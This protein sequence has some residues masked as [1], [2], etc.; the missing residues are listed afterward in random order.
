MTMQSESKENKILEQIVAASEEF[1]QSAG[2]K[3][4]YQKITDTIAGISGAKYAVFSLY[5]EGGNKFITTAITAPEGMIKKVSSLLGFKLLGKKW[6]YD[7]VRAW[8]T[9]S[10]TITHLSSLLELTGD[11]IPKPVVYLLEKT[12][13]IGEVVFVK[14]LKEN[15]M[16]G[17]FTLV[18]PNN[19]T[20]R[21]DNYV[22]LYSRQLGLLIT[23][24]RAENA[25]LESEEKFRDLAQMLPETI[26]EMNGQGILTFVNQHGFEVFGYT[27]QDFDRGV[28]GLDMLIPKD[29]AKA[30]KVIQNLFNGG[31]SGP[32]E[33]TAQR[34][35]GSTLPILLR[36]SAIFHDGK[37]VGLRGMVFD[38]TERK[39]VEEAL[40]E[41]KK[42]IERYLNI[43]AEIIISLD[44]LGNITMINESG[45]QLLG[46]N[47]DELIG[48]NWLSTCI[49]DE[50]ISD[51]KNVF[52]KIISGDVGNVTNFE[53]V[54]K[55]KSGEIRTIFW[56]NTILRDSNGNVTGTISS[57]EDITERKKAED[58][59]HMERERL[60]NILEGTNAGTWEWNIQTKK[61]V[62]NERW[63]EIIGYTLAEISPVSEGT[64][65]RFT[66]PDDI[67][68]SNEQLRRVFSREINY[69]DVECRMRHKNG[70]W[71]W[72]QD[73]GKVMSWTF[74][75]KP[76]W[77]SGTH[78]DIT[79][80]KLSEEALQA[81]EEK[82]SK[83]FKT[84]HHAI[85]ITR[86]KDGRFIEVNEAFTIITGFSR[87]EACADSSINLKIWVDIGNRDQVVSMLKE[88]MDVKNK[89][90]KFRKK[91]GAV[92]IGLFSAQIVHINNEPFMFSSISDITDRKKA[93]A[94]ILHLS[95][96]D[97]LTGL[98]NR[99]FFEEEL[100]RLDTER[101]L[102]ISFIMGDLNGLKIINDVFGHDEGDRLL[103][104]TG[105]ILK[106]VCRSDDILARWGGDEFVILLPKTFIADAEDIAE[107]I[108]K[109]CKK[110]KNQKIALSLSLGSAV[111]ES[112]I[113][114]IRATLV[115]A[116][117]NMYKNKLIEKQSLTSS[118]IFALEQALYEKS[119]ETKEHTDRIHELA[120][121]LGK[122]IKL[123]SSQLDELSLLAS[124][125]DI[126]KVAIPETILLKK[127]K[128]T[129]KEWSTIKR[130]PEI[131]FNIAQSSPQIAHIA[132]PILYCHENFDGS[133]YPMGIK[134]HEI[135]VISRIILIVDSYDV[136]TS[137]RSYKPAISKKDAITEIKRNAG[138]QFDPALVEKF[139]ELL[140][141]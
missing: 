91:N 127:G 75:G 55:T 120:G 119:N 69:Y 125:H 68:K 26:F 12:F 132:K 113:Q 32:N 122:S 108:K 16:I 88:G 77:M 114:D 47:R 86:L 24:K 94:E 49:P 141:D 1:L 48:R 95:F 126:G 57:G 52:E 116:E 39:R 60:A 29:R 96:H 10:S 20:L 22:E 97:H 35:D 45:H 43:V 73:R 44:N 41:S 62:Y 109:E 89:E 102:P 106:T 110:S 23:R 59:L 83:A 123:S 66:H 53:N 37:A 36:S 61:T 15:T 79:E 34:I 28:N 65:E 131:G 19:V 80:R 70:S 128:L 82:F 5:D 124:L 18:M 101:Q 140:A 74:D 4:N 90:F 54:V 99:R 67:E 87:E 6:D 64:W 117:S 129:E 63:A 46:Y 121:K 105:E 14:I 50:M 31:S 112:T 107:R 136:M 85:A 104:V 38:I 72:V 76:L 30:Q 134:G 100:K 13:K 33:Y 71:V 25:L 58:L 42:T 92:I 3:L 17:D 118:V 98:Y 56:R 21:N 27:R 137:G 9:K 103:K 7:Q 2:S 93:E 78:T 111:K 115:D 11:T 138:S 135:P 130:H 8:K 40:E 51:V 133:G 139:I 84:S 81:S